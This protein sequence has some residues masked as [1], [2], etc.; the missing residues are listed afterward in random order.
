VKANNVISIINNAIPAMMNTTI[1]TP[2]E[3]IAATV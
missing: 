2:L 3:S 1:T